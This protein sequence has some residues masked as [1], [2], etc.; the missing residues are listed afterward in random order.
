M[1]SNSRIPH[2]K[3]PKASPPQIEPEKAPDANAVF[4]ALSALG[5]PI[6]NEHFTRLYLGP[7]AD[8]LH[9]VSERIHGRQE[10]AKARTR[11]HLSVPN[12]PNLTECF[13]IIN[14]PVDHVATH[15]KMPARVPIWTKHIHG[16]TRVAKR[17]KNV[18]MSWK[19]CK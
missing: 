9:F 11:I 4:T 14:L 6:S 8:I 3:K 18:R 10:V 5:A 12:V 17:W 19:D 13:R 7:F 1:P 16:L 2:A 15:P